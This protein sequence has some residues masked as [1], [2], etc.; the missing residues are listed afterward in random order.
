MKHLIG[1]ML[2]LIFFPC[3]SQEIKF[4]YEPIP[5]ESG[6]KID[7]YWVWCG[8]MIKVESINSN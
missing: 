5:R 3:F 8:S 1:S 4:D 7:G 2:I 6:F